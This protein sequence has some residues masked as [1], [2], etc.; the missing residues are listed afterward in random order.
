MRIGQDMRKS[1]FCG[2]AWRNLFKAKGRM[3][4]K[5]GEEEINKKRRRLLWKRGTNVVDYILTIRPLNSP[6]S[7]PVILAILSIILTSLGAYIVN[8]LVE[9]KRNTEAL[10]RSRR[11]VYSQLKGNVDEITPVYK[12]LIMARFQSEMYKALLDKYRP[13]ISKGM[14]ETKKYEQKISRD[15][16]NKEYYRQREMADNRIIDIAKSQGK[17]LE[18]IGMIEVLFDHTDKLNKYINTITFN[19]H[20]FPGYIEKTIISELIYNFNA[21][22]DNLPSNKNVKSL[23]SETINRLIESEM[24]KAETK[25]EHE[26]NKYIRDPI[27]QLLKYMIDIIEKKENEELQ[28]WR[29]RACSP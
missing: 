11:Q 3:L 28:V 7:D 21:R 5:P 12:L 27:D 15:N 13:T 10:L 9:G 1:G 16:I 19:N 24:D 26:I 29:V 18:T 20:V 25:L 8:W 2:I 6:L 4:L 23:D 22:L 17:L 14:S